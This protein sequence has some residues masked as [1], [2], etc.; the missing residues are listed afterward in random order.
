MTSAA[1]RDLDIVPLICETI[2][3]RGKIQVEDVKALSRFCKRDIGLTEPEA[4]SVFMLAAENLP[5][6]AEWADFF[7]Q[8][9]SGW[10]TGEW[11]GKAIDADKAETLI[12]WLGGA[13]ASLS[14]VQFRMLTQTLELSEDCPEKLL[15]FARACLVRAMGIDAVRV[16]MLSRVA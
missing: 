10:I 8:T 13:N 14:P 3:R 2:Q 4:A 12:V 11:A 15:A 6:C 5:A 16:K 9:M 7:T 1:T